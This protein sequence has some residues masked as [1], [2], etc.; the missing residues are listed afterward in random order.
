MRK[1]KK[2]MKERERER[3][4]SREKT[5]NKK[6]PPLPCS[7]K[8]REREEPQKKTSIEA[9]KCNINRQQ[10][11]RETQENVNCLV[12][13]S[14]WRPPAHRSTRHIYAHKVRK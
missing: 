8:R 10:T 11:K 14:N 9:A 4:K 12:N 5:T 6:P 3:G 2:K 1:K 7:M 13:V